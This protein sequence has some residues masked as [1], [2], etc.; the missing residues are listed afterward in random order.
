MVGKL[1]RDVAERLNDVRGY[2]EGGTYSVSVRE[3][4]CVL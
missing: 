4:D 3:R 2:T 1:Y